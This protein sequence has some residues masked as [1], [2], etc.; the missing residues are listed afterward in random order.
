VGTRPRIEAAQV[1]PTTFVVTARGDL[2]DASSVELRDLLLPLVAAEG[3]CVV[4]D[5]LG[6]HDLEDG[7]LGVVLTAAHMLERRGRRLTVVA[8]SRHLT[9]L[10]Y[11]SGLD[12]IATLERSLSAGLAHAH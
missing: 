3:S 8:A 10:A 7:C 9:E 12:R 2:D 11:A 5:L 6:V 1:T 4:L